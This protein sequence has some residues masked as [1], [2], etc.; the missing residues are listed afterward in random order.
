M[1]KY[2]ILLLTLIMAG[3]SDNVKETNDSVILYRDGQFKKSVVT[4][5]GVYCTVAWY[6]SIENL[7]ITPEG[8]AIDGPFNYKWTLSQFGSDEDKAW[9][10]KNCK[11]K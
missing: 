4:K 8:T 2:L 7:Y 3:C 5:F 6:E 1:Y 11:A 9:Y 10:A